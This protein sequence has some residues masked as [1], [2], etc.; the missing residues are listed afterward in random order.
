MS[1]VKINTSLKIKMFLINSMIIASKERDHRLL[2]T[3]FR[4]LAFR[5][6]PLR[7]TD[8]SEHYN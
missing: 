6:M 5:T 4:H 8:G 7:V 3:L 2:P 1:V